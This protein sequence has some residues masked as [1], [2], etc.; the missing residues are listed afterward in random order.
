MMQMGQVGEHD[1]GVILAGLA[2]I[3]GQ[4]AGEKLFRT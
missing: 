3:V 2:E 4:P 1:H